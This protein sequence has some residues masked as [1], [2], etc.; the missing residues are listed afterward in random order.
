MIQDMITLLI[1]FACS[2][3][4]LYALILMVVPSKKKAVSH[5]AGC[6]GCSIKMIKNPV[7]VHS[8]IHLRK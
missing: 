2:G 7:P 3:Y 5:C 1:V 8:R 4:A 6:A